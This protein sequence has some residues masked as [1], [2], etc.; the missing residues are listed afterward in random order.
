MKLEK[1]FYLRN[2]VVL[3]A[4]DLLGKYLFSSASGALTGGIIVETEAYSYRERA[5]HSYNNRRTRR[6]EV[7]FG[8]GGRAYV[9]LI[10][11]IHYLFNIVTNVSEVAEAV[12]I[13]AVEPTAGVDH[14]KARRA[15]QRGGPQLTSGPGKLSQALGIT[16]AD[17][18][19]SLLGDRIWLED[20]GCRP[21]KKDV[22]AG[23]RIGVDYAQEDA[24]LPWRFYIRNNRWVSG[25]TGKK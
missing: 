19:C 10:Y 3:V 25:P 23:P 8:E 6:T 17:H 12:L 18:A 9:Y 7:M 11:G 5:S 4:R 21:G 15:I 1:D 2:D 24:L 20:R 14:M 13:R 16:I 22:V